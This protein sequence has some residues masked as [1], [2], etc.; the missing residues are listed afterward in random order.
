MKIQRICPQCIH[1]GMNEH[2]G[3][4]TDEIKP[5]GVCNIPDAVW[6]TCDHCGHEE[7]TP[8]LSRRIS[9]WI[10]R[11]DPIGGWERAMVKRDEKRLA[12]LR[13]KHK[14]GN[15]RAYAKMV[16]AREAAKKPR[17]IEL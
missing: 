5:Y 8:V 2:H 13:E 15:R 7:L 10:A 17:E 3:T 9:L 16:A 6:F 1:R 12:H 11:E 4:W 14:Q